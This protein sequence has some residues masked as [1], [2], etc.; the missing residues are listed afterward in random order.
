MTKDEFT[1]MATERATQEKIKT[2]LINGDYITWKTLSKGNP[3]LEKVTT[4][5]KFKTLQ[6]IES[7]KEKI[8]ELSTELGIESGKDK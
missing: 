2:A 8:N 3:I 1:K 4:E 7:Y 6:E 5:A